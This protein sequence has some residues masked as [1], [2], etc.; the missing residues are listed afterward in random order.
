MPTAFSPIFRIAEMVPGGPEVKNSW[1]AIQ[2]A[3][4]PLYEQ[5]AAGVIS[6]SIAGMT[7]Y[8][9][10]TANN[11]PDQARYALYSFTGA[12]AGDCTVTAPNVQRIGKVTNV[13]TGGHNI[14]L[15]T[16][17]GTKAIIPS[18]GFVYDWTTDG[19]G[20]TRILPTI[21]FS[22]FA[23]LAT[24]SGH[25][26]L[27]GGVTLNWGNGSS[28]VGLQTV[29]FSKGFSTGPWCVLMT[30][31]DAPNTGPPAAVGLELTT[32]VTNLGF[33]MFSF[34]TTTGALTAANFFWFAI[35]PT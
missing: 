7:T 11:A 18:D 26:D 31:K 16:G 24:F 17:A 3:S 19:S 30:L 13:T 8:S 4:V 15:S 5:G 27:P 32:V 14:I 22:Q 34:N 12:L 23:P 29:T 25:I 28:G 1:G 21:N 20:N 2:T 35:G 33:N 6:V 10:T 9:L